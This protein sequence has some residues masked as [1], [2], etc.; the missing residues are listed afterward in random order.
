MKIHIHK[1][2]SDAGNRS[3]SPRG[4]VEKRLPCVCARANLSRP[5]EKDTVY[6]QY[7]YTVHIMDIAL[8]VR[9]T[10]AVHVVFG[11]VVAI[12]MQLTTLSTYRR[13]KRIDEANL[14]CRYRFKI[15]CGG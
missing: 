11:T 8:P 2:T 1:K 13:M 15:P 4:E 9:G 14:V 6:S 10:K 5:K 7:Y 3:A 12:Y